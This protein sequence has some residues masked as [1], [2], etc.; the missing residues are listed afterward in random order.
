MPVFT[1]LL[2]SRFV[3]P[4]TPL[5]VDPCTLASVR[6]RAKKICAQLKRT[7]FCLEER[8]AKSCQGRTAEAEVFGQTWEFSIECIRE[9][10]LFAT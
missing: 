8:M 4:E 6:I 7:F 1:S 3:D 10:P 2:R 5:E 9:T